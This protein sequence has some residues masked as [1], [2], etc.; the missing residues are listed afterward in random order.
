MENKLSPHHLA[1]FLH[2]FGVIK[3]LFNGN[4]LGGWVELGTA[5]SV[6]FCS[7]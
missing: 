5:R 1:D 2:P 6:L 4:R 3:R 7:T